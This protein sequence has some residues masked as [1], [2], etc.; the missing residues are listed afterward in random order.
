MSIKSRMK[1][2]VLLKPLE[3]STTIETIKE[4][5]PDREIQVSFSMISGSTITTNNTLITSSTHIGLTKERD[6]NN[7]YRIQDGNSIYTI[8]Y[9]NGDGYYNQ[10]FLSLVE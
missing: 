10:L 4:Y 2:V 1:T 7:N 6:I 8:T 3:S 5:I 9:V